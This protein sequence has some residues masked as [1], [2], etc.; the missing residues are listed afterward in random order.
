MPNSN[1]TQVM[2]LYNQ[3]KLNWVSGEI[4]ALLYLGLTQ[5]LAHQR[6]SNLGSS[7][8]AA[9][10]VTGRSITIDGKALG[11]PATFQRV[12]AATGYQVVVV[13]DDGRGD[14]LLLTFIE[15]NMTGNPLAVSHSGSLIVRPVEP[16]P[17][18]LPGESA[19][20]P[21]VGVWMALS[22]AA[23]IPVANLAMETT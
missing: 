7:P 18:P 1:Y 9:A 10:S 11:L 15:E 13:L 19:L 8:I 22:I 23:P 6:V 17:D 4:R 3:G 14:P 12:D 21:T 20:P 5:N 2:D 16:A